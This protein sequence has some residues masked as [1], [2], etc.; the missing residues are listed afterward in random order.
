MMRIAGYTQCERTVTMKDI[1]RATK[2]S[3]VSSP[4]YI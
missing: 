3:R 4:I 2:E 1:Q